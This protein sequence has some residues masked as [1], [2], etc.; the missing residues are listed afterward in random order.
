[1]PLP[2]HGRAP[3][4]GAG[5]ARLAHEAVGVFQLAKALGEALAVAVAEQVGE[6]GHAVFP[7][8]TTAP[9]GSPSPARA[10]RSVVALPGWFLARLACPAGRRC[11]PLGGWTVPGT[12]N[13]NSDG[14]DT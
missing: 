1:M 9:L 14:S 7:R 3:P 5:R 6:R 13:N 10:L 12:E 4:G 8:M 11:S 2:S